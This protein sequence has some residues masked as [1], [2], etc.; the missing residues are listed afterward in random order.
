MF[1]RAVSA[2]LTG[3]DSHSIEVEADVSPGLP[4]FELVGY[5]SAEVKEARE[6]VRTA[7]RNA[8]YHLEPRRVIV[9][10]SPADMHKS[11]SSYDLAI[12][13]AVLCAYGHIPQRA[14]EQIVIVG[15]L[16]LNGS[17]RGVNGILSV[18]MM[19]RRLGFARCIVPA[20]NAFEGAAVEGMQVY[21][22]RN[23]KEMTAFLRGEYEIA[24]AGINGMALSVGGEV[25]GAEGSGDGKVPDFSDISGQHSL[26]RGMEI[27]AAGMHH[28]LMVG[29]PGAGKSMAARRLPTILPAMSWEESLEVSEIY[30][31][32]GL[33]RP[34]KGLITQRPFRTPHHTVSDVA[35]A[36]GGRI[37]KPGEISLAH[38]GVLFLD[39][40]TEFSSQAMEIMR[41]PL[42]TG[43]MMINRVHGSCEFPA[44]F[45]L[46]A[47]INPCRC[48]YYPD[49]RRCHCTPLQIRR[50][51]GRISQPLMDRIDLNIEVR[52]V[53]ID[54]LQQ[55]RRPEEPSAA[56]RGRVE[57]ARHVQALRYEGT[58]YLYNSQLTDKAVERYCAL[59][60]SEAGFMKQVYERFEISARSYHK[61]LKVARTIADLAGQE[62]ITVEALREAVFYKAIDR[63]YWGGDFGKG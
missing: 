9:N 43:R 32:A 28:V 54:F 24:A 5:L 41:Q 7:V 38:R 59:G 47:A 45:M 63:G 35:L 20:D 56:I 17:V 21:G 50:Y 62:Q 22:V 14:L 26:K 60:Q 51:L 53:Q 49:V 46:V 36:G 37:P 25:F 13:A 16:S 11:G 34:E 57:R 19:A 30:S 40:L 61:I 31:A 27:A 52:P 23:L 8:G 12:A 33:L 2:V 3:I 48:G 18:V 58:E 42:E 4:Y 15:E 6:R 55:N 10:L 39:E 29:P 44:S 1:S